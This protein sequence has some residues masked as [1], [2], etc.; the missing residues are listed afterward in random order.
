MVGMYTQLAHLYDWAGS[1]EF[2]EAVWRKDRALL[3]AQ[4]IEPPARILDLACGTGNLS[5]L[6]AQ[7]G[8]DVLGLDIAPAMLDEARR[9]Q[10]E[11]DPQGV[12]KMCFSQDDMRYFLLD[13]P[14]D[15]VLCHYDS[16]NHLSNES[17]LRG[18]FAQ[19]AQALRPGG[20]FLFDLNTLENY[21]TFWN[22]ND[23]D[24]GPNYR[25]RTTSRFDEGQGKAEVLFHV[26][27]YNEEGE[28]IAREESVME[29]YFNETAVEKYLMAADFYD[30]RHEP[31]NPVADLSSDFPLKTFWQCRRR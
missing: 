3:E 2:A 19:V 11:Q 1:L 16:L 26:D 17:E 10:A 27:E 23:T 28:L 22:G 6:L 20:L 13:T 4:G 31:F 7:A 21:R 30:I 9:K 8:Y 24:E 25:L 15:A 14:M 5:L 18:V 12:W 29:Q